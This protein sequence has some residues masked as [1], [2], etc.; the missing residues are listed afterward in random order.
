MNS[1]HHQYRD[2]HHLILPS[3]IGKRV[4]QLLLPNSKKV[5]KL[6]RQLLIRTYENFCSE[7][8]IE[9]LFRSTFGRYILLKVKLVFTMEAPSLEILELI[10][11]FDWERLRRRWF[12]NSYQIHFF[13]RYRPRTPSF[14]VLSMIDQWNKLKW[15]QRDPQWSKKYHLVVLKLTFKVCKGSLFLSSHLM[16]YL[17]FTFV[18][19]FLNFSRQR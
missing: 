6:R 1:D 17:N 18:D 4:K 8:L 2:D 19:S 13:R 12:E 16:I 7:K 10:F 3:L 11:P 9:K 5:E 15:V 14:L